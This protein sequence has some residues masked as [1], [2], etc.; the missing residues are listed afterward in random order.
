MTA[1]ESI[2]NI[3]Y[4]HSEKERER[5]REK[6]SSFDKSRLGE[7]ERKED[8]TMRSRKHTQRERRR[9]RVSWGGSMLMIIVFSAVL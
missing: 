1:P 4:D 6:L 3:D 5:E 9:V 2:Q 7:E 8:A